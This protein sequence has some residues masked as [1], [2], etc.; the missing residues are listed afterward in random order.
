M[1]PNGWEGNRI[2]VALPR[3]INVSGLGKGDERLPKLCSGKWCTLPFQ[4]QVTRLQR[5][6]VFKLVFFWFLL[7]TGFVQRQYQWRRQLVG[8][9][10]RA[11]PLAF[12][13][14]FFR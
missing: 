7:T 3:V 9:W 2:G 14:I 10:A 13:R 1:S 5:L 11:P 8:T 4:A 12:E 6:L